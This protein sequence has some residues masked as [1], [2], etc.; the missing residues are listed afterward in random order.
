MFLTVNFFTH[1]ISSL[2]NLLF[3]EITYILT[4]LNPEHPLIIQTL[5]R[6]RILNSIATQRQSLKRVEIHT[7]QTLE[8]FDE[9]VVYREDLQGFEVYAAKAGE[10]LD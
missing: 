5:Q 1:S 2:E 9:V 3:S 6:Q 4:Q 7:D 8:A 10:I